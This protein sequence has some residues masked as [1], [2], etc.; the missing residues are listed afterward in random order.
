[1]GFFLLLLGSWKIAK[2]KLLLGYF[3]F[4]K[5][6]FAIKKKK[7][8]PAPSALL[9]RSASVAAVLLANVHLV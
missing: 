4:A 5:S 1:V 7:M 9:Y 3:C 8:F 2:Q 6:A